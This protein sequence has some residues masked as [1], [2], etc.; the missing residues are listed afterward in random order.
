[1]AK[2]RPHTPSAP[3]GAPDIDAGERAA[4]KRLEEL[5]DAFD[6]LTPDELA[7]IGYRRP[8]DEE[9]DPLLDALDDA[10][11]RTGRVALMNEARETTRAAVMARYSEG[12][13]H[14]TFV[15]L[16]W[17]LS[18]GTVEDRVAI[19]EALA[20]AAAVAVVADVLDPEVA[21]ALTRDAAAI[22][23]LAA[24]EASEGSLA[25]AF[26]DPDDPDLRAGLSPVRT[27]R[28]AFVTLVVTAVVASFGIL[29]AAAVAV[30]AG[31]RA[32]IRS[33]TRGA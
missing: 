11:M 10:A 9:R 32:M 7:R 26:R 4:R 1:M 5:F 30:V 28:V 24:G 19:S 6:R 25:R 27:R 12:S 8:S 17:G 21:A 33:A 18:Q 3:D 2:D 13:Y 29:G 16:N 14:P 22:T 20:D 23:N 15:G 31:V